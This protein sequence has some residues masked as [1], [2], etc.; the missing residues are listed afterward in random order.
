MNDAGSLDPMVA[1]FFITFILLIGVVGVNIVLTVLVESFT[2]T[3]QAK[4]RRARRRRFLIIA[5]LI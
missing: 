2:S 1:I 5:R 4:V 3:V